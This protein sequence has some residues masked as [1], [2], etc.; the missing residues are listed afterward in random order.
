MRAQLRQAGK[1]DMVVSLAGRG[2]RF[3]ANRPKFGKKFS[4]KIADKLTSMMPSKL[5]ENGINF[6]LTK[7]HC[8][9]MGFMVLRA[10]VVDVD[11]L[12]LLEKAK[13]SEFAQK[14]APL[15]GVARRFKDVDKIVV[16][17]VQ[18]QIMRKLESE[19][20][21]MMFEKARFK[22]L[23]I[24]RSSAE[25][26]DFFFDAL[27]SHKL[28]VLIKVLNR[29]ELAPKI[30]QERA[31]GFFG[32][33]VGRGKYLGKLAGKVASGVVSRT[34]DETFGKVVARRL[35]RVL[36]AYMADAGVTM[37]VMKGY[38]AS[39]ESSATCLECEIVDV[40]LP[41]FR[42][43]S[44]SASAFAGAMA[45]E[46]Q[47]L[48]L[49]HKGR[50]EVYEAVRSHIRDQFPQHLLSKKG[51][52]IQVT[53]RNVISAP[54]EMMQLDGLSDSDEGGEEE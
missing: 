23:M 30:A 7:V 20:P 14:V 32:D 25:Q 12:K 18:Q 6:K 11:L 3:L 52:Q 42:A 5:E 54:G 16:P 27:A 39:D 44:P 4:N 37:S 47:M 48:K 53:V 45:E 9:E 33:T 21:N 40:D 34:S 8:G 41:T 51:V 2:G 35:S 49:G 17:K 38:V 26:A 50:S 36:P 22:M 46:Q 28:E 24:C 15:V 31:E 13:G 29:E 19:I 10:Q 43:S 1:G